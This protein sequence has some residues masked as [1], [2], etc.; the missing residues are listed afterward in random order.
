MTTESSKRQQSHTSLNKIELRARRLDLNGADNH[1][2]FQF[3]YDMRGFIGIGLEA[4]VDGKRLAPNAAI[5]LPTLLY[6]AHEPLDGNSYF[7]ALF[8]C[9]CGVA[10]CAG[11]CDNVVVTHEEYFILWSC[12]YPINFD[13]TN[14]RSTRN[15]VLHFRFRRQE[16]LAQQRRLIDTIRRIA[17]CNESRYRIPVY[18]EFVNELLAKGMIPGDGSK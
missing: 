9:G 3:Y 12:P 1:E 14:D 17:H 4:W 2:K 13:R 11:L 16:M 7:S 8:T 10:G 18:E 6:S 5:D 15:E